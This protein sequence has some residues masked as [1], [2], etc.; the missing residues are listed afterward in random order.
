MKEYTEFRLKSDGRRLTII[1]KSL[2]LMLIPIICITYLIRKTEK[3][4][5]SEW[6]ESD[7]GFYVPSCL[8]NICC[9]FYLVKILCDYCGK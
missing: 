5:L 7:I 8:I 4:S 6:I 3:E 2:G 9:I 1:I